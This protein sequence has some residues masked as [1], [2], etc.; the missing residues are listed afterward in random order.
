M[1]LSMSEIQTMLDMR[2]DTVTK[3]TDAMWEAMGGAKLGD[4]GRTDITGRGEDPTVYELEMLAAK[5]TG[6][7]DAIYM[8][9]GCMCNHCA[10]FTATERGDKV[11]VEK[12]AHVYIDEKFDFLPRYGGLV[13]IFYHLAPDFQI[14]RKEIEYLLADGDIK[15][16]WLENSHNHSGGT[17]LSVET[18]RMA[19]DLAHASGAHV[20]LDGARIFNAAV[21]LGVDVRELT[22]PVDSLMFCV[23]KG[24]S[25]PV[26][27]LLVGSKAFIDKA[28]A[29]KKIMGTGM[30]QA[31]VIAAAGI[32]ALEP[33][34]IAR[35]KEDHDNAAHLGK[36]LAVIDNAILNPKA[37][38]TNFVFMNVSPTGLTALQVAEGLRE[39]GLLVAKMTDTNIRIAA[40]R[41]ITG[42]DVEK[43]AEIIVDY[44]KSLKK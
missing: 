44:F 24:L 14:D 9:S 35:L 34:N 2:S 22:A 43:A 21:A 33:E 29:V 7:E 20:H 18:T 4:A 36:L 30:R 11:L 38:Q 6:K 42:K 5:M 25:A 26:G 23:S 8:A 39:K 32:V 17:C 37:D 27:S 12:S 41:G 13:P 1:A 19:C 40:H 28:R 10:L 31:G 16:L 15:V 3:P